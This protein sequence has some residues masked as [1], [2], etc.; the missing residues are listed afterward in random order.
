MAEP[1]ED[2]ILPR[3]IE[4]V[5]PFECCQYGPWVAMQETMAYKNKG[6]ASEVAFVV[7]KGE[8]VMTIGGEYLVRRAGKAILIEDHCEDDFADHGHEFLRGE[9][10][11]LLAYL[12]EGAWQVWHR[13]VF[14]DL[15]SFLARPELHLDLP[16]VE[17]SWPQMEWWIHAKSGQGAEGWLRIKVLQPEDEKSAIRFD[18]DFDGMDGC[19]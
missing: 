5:C 10:V 13:G 14:L 18:L 16:G 4:D 11:A 2:L 9:E 17:L 6:D 19:D 15:E 7:R 8:S 1:I 3:V 12:G